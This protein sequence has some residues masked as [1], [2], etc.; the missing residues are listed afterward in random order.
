MAFIGSMLGQNGT[1]LNYRAQGASIAEPTTAAQ[2]Q[3]AYTQSQ[4]ALDKQRALLTALQAQNGIQHQEDVYQQQQDLAAGKGPNP[5]KAMLDTATGNNV[6][7]QAALMAGQRGSSANAGLIARQAAQ[8]GANIEQQA[9]GQG[10]VLQANQS[11]NAMNNAGNIAGQQVGQEIGATGTLNQATQSEQQN[12][13]NAISG[14]NNAKVAMQSNINNANAGLAGIAAQGQQALVGG[15][16]SGAG[17][18]MMAEGGE[19]KQQPGAVPMPTPMFAGGGPVHEGVKFLYSSAPD[20]N[21]APKVNAELASMGAGNPGASAMNAG[22]AKFG[23]GMGKMI[24]RATAPG[25]APGPSNTVVNP[26][27]A[28]TNNLAHGGKVPAKV[29][30]G[31]LYLPPKAAKKVAEG[32]ANPMSVGERIPGKPKV[33][34]NSYANDTVDKTLQSG[35]VVV[36]N[37]E[38]QSEDPM[39]HARRFV[40]AVYAK[41]GHSPLRGKKRAA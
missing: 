41:S 13:L 2:A 12:L 36:P 15:L 1:G 32:K 19:V 30:P 39:E 16:M 29:S 14:Q 23:Q 5:A 20:Q 24:G 33:K 26:E 27:L 7:N 25:A 22:T 28:M 34:G 6:A 11:M 17:S 31:E 35:G 37:S 4:E 10:A 38:M 9:A 21:S 8:Q 18:A 40:A 3:T